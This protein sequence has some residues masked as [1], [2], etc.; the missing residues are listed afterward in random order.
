MHSHEIICQKWRKNL[1]KSICIMIYYLA[2]Q[3]YKGYWEILQ[4][5]PSIT[6]AYGWV[7]IFITNPFIIKFSTPETQFQP[8]Q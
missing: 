3:K 7:K 5:K 4:T 2:F 8:P 1:H 6:E